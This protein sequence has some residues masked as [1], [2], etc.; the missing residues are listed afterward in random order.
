MLKSSNMKRDPLRT[1][2]ILAISLIG[3]SDLLF[4][5]NFYNRSAKRR[6][7]SLEAF[8]N[9]AHNTY[10]LI[11]VKTQYRPKKLS[12][13]CWRHDKQIFQI[14]TTESWWIWKIRAVD[15]LFFLLPRKLKTLKTLFFLASPLFF[16]CSSVC[17][18]LCLCS[19]NY[20]MNNRNGEKVELLFCSSLHSLL[21]L[22]PPELTLSLLHSLYIPYEVSGT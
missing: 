10:K 7:W 11:H 8:S 1:K 13:L 5:I 3:L 16:M 19:S 20:P 17:S 21:S 18:Q 22:T 9:R 6:Q 14:P 2:Q 4:K 12:L 15:H